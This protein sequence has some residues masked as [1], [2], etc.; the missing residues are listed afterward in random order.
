MAPDAAEVNGPADVSADAMRTGTVTR[1]T[2]P[3]APAPAPAGES[4]PAKAS[5]GW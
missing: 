4:E 3:A 5:G 1:G 2:T